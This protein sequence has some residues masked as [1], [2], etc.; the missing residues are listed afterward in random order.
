[1]KLKTTV[2]TG[3]EGK[4]RDKNSQQSLHIIDELVH[5]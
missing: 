3:V 4:K 2:K 1:M 5:F